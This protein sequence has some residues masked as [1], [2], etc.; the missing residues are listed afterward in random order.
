MK[1]KYLMLAIG[2]ILSFSAQCQET[3]AKVSF[4]NGDRL[5]LSLFTTSKFYPEVQ[6]ESNHLEIQDARYAFLIRND[7]P[8][9]ELSLSW[10]IGYSYSDLYE[11]YCVLPI[12]LQ[13]AN[14]FSEHVTLSIGLEIASDLIEETRIKPLIGVS[15]NF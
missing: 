4:H 7:V 14:V 13:K 8:V 1:K 3:Q 9:K 2:A 15:I 6:I 10:G 5:S 12:E 11:S